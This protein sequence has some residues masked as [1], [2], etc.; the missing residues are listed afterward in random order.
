MGYILPPLDMQIY[1][2]ER[3]TETLSV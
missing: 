3:T 2:R 1:S